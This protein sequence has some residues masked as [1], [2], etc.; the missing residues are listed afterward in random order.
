[1]NDEQLAA[2]LHPVAYSYDE[3]IARLQKMADEAWFI[4][5]TRQSYIPIITDVSRKIA[6]AADTAKYFS[7]YSTLRYQ[8]T[9]LEKSRNHGK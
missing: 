2:D 1:M 4:A 6:I 3:E 9:F 8:I 5:M 7:R